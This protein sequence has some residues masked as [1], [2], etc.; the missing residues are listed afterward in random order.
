[1]PSTQGSRSI[2]PRTFYLFCHSY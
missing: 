2:A 1:M